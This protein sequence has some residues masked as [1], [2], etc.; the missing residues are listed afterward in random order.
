MPR[1][2]EHRRAGELDLDRST[3]R[4]SGGQKQRLALAG[5]LAMR[6]RVIVLDEPTANLD[7]KAWRCAMPSSGPARKPAPR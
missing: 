5:V 6:P 2:P 3:H 4:L 7:R 1:I